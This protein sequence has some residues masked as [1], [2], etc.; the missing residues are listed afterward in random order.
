MKFINKASAI[1]LLA[2]SNAYASQLPPIE[3][4]AG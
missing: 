3:E 2:S 1:M 4:D